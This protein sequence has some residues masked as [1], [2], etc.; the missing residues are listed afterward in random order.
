MAGYRG[1]LGFGGAIAVA[2]VATLSAYTQIKDTQTLSVIFALVLVGAL[3]PDIDSD[4]GL[5]FFLSYG[6]FTLAASAVITYHTLL[7]THDPQQRLLIPIAGFIILWVIGGTIVKRFTH[8]RG[9]FHSLPAM[10]VAM[11]GA[12][13]EA[14]NLHATPLHAALFGLAIGIGFLSHLLLDEI[15]AL[16]GINSYSFLPLP[17]KAFGTALKLWSHSRSAS[18][19]CYLLLFVLTYLAMPTLQV[20]LAALPLH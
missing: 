10:A 8:H 2:G 19:I 1:H 20:V 18:L 5:P 17:N 9:I 3:L 12:L 14:T 6:I 7:L 15:Y 16:L 4:S 13:L 11:L